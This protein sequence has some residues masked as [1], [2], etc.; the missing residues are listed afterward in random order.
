MA[1]SKHY[2]CGSITFNSG[3]D[4]FD[5]DESGTSDCESEN[6]A[7]ESICVMSFATDNNISIP[8]CSERIGE[9]GQTCPVCHTPITSR[10]QI[11]I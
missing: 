11:Y 2:W 5:S 10:F 6:L 3:I 1:V 4:I 8:T 9:L 7:T